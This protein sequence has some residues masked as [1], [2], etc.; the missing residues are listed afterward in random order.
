MCIVPF[1][2]Q[3]ATVLSCAACDLGGHD[4]QP[5]EPLQIVAA[6]PYSAQGLDCESDAGNDCGFPADAPLRLKFD[7]W[8]LPTTAVRQ[9]V[10]LV[11][12][13]TEQAVFLRPDYDVT[14]RVLAIR[15]DT[16]LA[17][18]SVYLLQLISADQDPNGFGFRAYDGGALSAPSTFAFRT[19]APAAQSNV[20]L[21]VATCDEVLSAIAQAGCTQAGCHSGPVPRMGLS[22]ENASGLLSTA[23]DQVAHETE[24]GPDLTQQAVSGGRFG[25]QMPIIDSGRPE[26]SY[27]IYKLLIG[28]SLNNEFG[29]EV[30]RDH[31]APDP[32]TQAAIEQAR[33]WFIEFGPMPPDEVGYPAG[34]SPAELVRTLQSWIRAGATCP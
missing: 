10:S 23:I 21:P 5:G 1:F 27:L 33:A 25:V 2:L 24:S 29:A 22:L 34:V 4:A 26:N 32:M 3:F 15:P 30:N 20:A 19:S 6:E 28:S 9:S 18:G 11:T 31:F 16:P 13:G 14:A 7:R 8:L 12:E 17:A